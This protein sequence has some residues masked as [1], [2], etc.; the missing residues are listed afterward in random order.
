MSNKILAVIKRELKER[1]MS[2]AFI[3]MTILIP[4]FMFGL[5]GIQAFLY[6]FDG[7]DKT[8]I[9]IVSE[10]DDLTQRLENE[11]QDSN[12]TKD[13]NFNFIYRTQTKPAFE[14]Y[15]KT[16]GKADILDE[17]IH[18]I[19]F[20]P[21]SALTDKK[22]EYYSKTPKN[23]SI[24]NKVKWPINKILVDEYFINKQLSE[25]DL[26]FARSGVDFTGFKVSKD[27]EIE[28]EGYGNLILSY[29][30]SF[31]LYISL[32]MMGSLTMQSVIEEKQN[33]IVEVLLS[34]LNAKELMTGKILGT[35]ITG[36]LQMAI[37]LSP[38]I[39]L[40]STT[41]FVLPPEFVLSITFTQI[42]YLL[43]N[44]F[45]GLILFVGLFAT[46]G[47]IF[48]NAQDAQSGVWPVMMLII[49]PFFISLAFIRNPTNPIGEI[50]S[51][52]P[53]ASIII[54]PVKMTIVDTSFWQPILALILNV[55][56]IFLIF[57][58]AGKVYRIGILRTGKKPSWGEVVKWIRFS[59]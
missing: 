30:F 5:I 22:I 15:I 55:A 25:E 4:V 3:I 42:L 48:E 23:F 2:K 28:E 51:F 32:L 38:I 50:G 43:A 59:N 49:I 57:P 40:V 6:S 52:V 33:R 1:V 10:A 9:E 18:G 21:S 54:M 26:A 41:V 7:S 56:A 44:F 16:E 24:T 46:I 37:W 35:A 14:D 58:L 45:I 36:L 12:L 8:T 29:A 34:S 11:I 47:S 53:F 31:L 17:K 39:F 13:E 27:S 20:I 19:F